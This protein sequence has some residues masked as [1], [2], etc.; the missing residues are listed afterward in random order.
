VEKVSGT[1]SEEEGLTGEEEDEGTSS[2]VSEIEKS[3]GGA[4]AIRSR[5]NWVDGFR[6][7]ATHRDFL[8]LF[9]Y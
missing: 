8:F 1:T 3:S 6:D 9:H 2:S 4:L 7:I 5:W